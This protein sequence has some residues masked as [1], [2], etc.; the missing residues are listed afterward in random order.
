MTS[1]ETLAREFSEESLKKT[2]EAE[3]F[4][5]V[6]EDVQRAAVLVS[7]TVFVKGYTRTIAELL[8][9]LK[10][11]EV[12]KDV[13]RAYLAQSEAMLD[14]LHYKNGYTAGFHA[15]HNALAPILLEA[16]ISIELISK[17][18]PAI[19]SHYPGVPPKEYAGKQFK[20]LHAALLGAA[21]GE[22]YASK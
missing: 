8:E 18:H 13:V 16:F 22:K 14:P 7:S 10:D 5:F 4:K 19:V 2:L 15:C 11:C 6:T 9:A 20:K 3:T 1:P 21:K 12:P 17:M